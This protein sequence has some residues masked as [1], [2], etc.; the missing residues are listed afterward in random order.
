MSD[1]PKIRLFVDQSL[2]QDAQIALD[3]DQSHYLTRVMRLRDGAALRAFNGRDGEW[4]ARIDGG[5]KNTTELK[6]ETLLRAPDQTPDIWLLFAPLKKDRTNFLIEKA[7]E[8]GVAHLMPV[9]TDF[10][11][12]ARVNTERLQ[13]VAREATE[14]CEGFHI[15][16]IATP[17]TLDTALQ[18]WPQDRHLL[19]CDETKLGAATALPAGPAALL[20][21]PEGG[22]SPKERARLHAHRAARPIS[23]GPKIL[24]VETAAIAA[25]TYWHST[26]GLWR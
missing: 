4:S 2:H 14:Q 19:F 22:F 9:L 26:Q 3:R 6:L 8:L 18:N 1:E 16:D 10:T 21:G 12:A 23:L 17:V 24:R 11:N 15:P 25:L 20:I 7:T 5:T 13:A